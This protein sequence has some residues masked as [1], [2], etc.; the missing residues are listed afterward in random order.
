MNHAMVGLSVILTDAEYREIFRE[1]AP[2]NVTFDSKYGICFRHVLS[3]LPQLV[4]IVEHDDTH[5]IFL[6][7]ESGH[8]N[9]GAAAAMLKEYKSIADRRLARMVKTV[10]YAG[11]RECFGVQASDMLAFTSL[12]I[13]RDGLVQQVTTDITHDTFIEGH[14]HNRPYVFRIPITRETLAQL[15]EGHIQLARWRRRY[16]QGALDAMSAA[17]EAVNAYLETQY[18]T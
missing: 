9:Q 16:G 4:D 17:R 10:S 1:H 14:R 5:R 12:R 7:L 15:R 11:K 6:V 18:V 2:R 8:K 13:E 3:F